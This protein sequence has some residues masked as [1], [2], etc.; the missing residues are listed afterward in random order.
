MTATS[1][2]NPSGIFKN[3]RAKLLAQKYSLDLNDKNAYIHEH[4]LIYY[5]D[6]LSIVYNLWLDHFNNHAPKP[7]NISF[8]EY[9]YIY[10]SLQ[11]D[12]QET[13]NFRF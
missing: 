13:L 6:V 4:D 10:C 9:S 3:K 7:I 2:R 1:A 12:Q 8:K 5:S 11:Q